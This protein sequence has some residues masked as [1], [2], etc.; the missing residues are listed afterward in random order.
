MPH[1][2]PLIATLAVGFVLAF[3][4]GFAAQRLRLP[5]LVGYLLAGVAIGPFT[6]GFVADAELAAQLAEVGVMLLMFGVGLHFSVADLMAVRRIAIPGAVLQIVLATVIGAALAMFWGWSL[7]AGLVL[8]LSL[9]VAS[10]VVLLK[11]L[12]ERNAI[13]TPN[14]RIAVGWLIVE[15]LAMVLVLVL[16]PAFAE[17]LGGTATVGGHA[18]EAAEHGLL[19]TLGITLAKVGCF[20]G[21]V[22]IFGP[23]L[24]PWILRQVARTGSRELFTLSVLAVALGVAFG[25]AKLFG[26]SFALGAFFAGVVLSESELSHRAAEKSLPLQDAFAVLF[27]VSVGML[28]D[29]SILLREPLMVLAVLAVILIGK[30]IIS[31]VIV[32]VL[33]YPLSTAL[34]VSSALAQ[35]GEFSFI[36][37]GIGVAHGLLPAEGLSLILAGALLSITVNPLVFVATD[38]ITTKIKA[39]EGWRRRFEEKRSGPLDRLQG[40]LDAVRARMAVKAAAHKT[41]SPEELVQKFPL[42]E[43]LSEE[44]REALVLHFHP[45]SAQPG[46]RV[47]RAGDVADEAYFISSGEVEVSVSGRRIKLRAGAVFG[48]MAL[49]SGQPRSADVTAIDYSEFLTLS[50]G[51]FRQFVRKYPSIRSQVAALAAQRGQMNEQWFE[52]SANDEP[53]D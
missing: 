47:I 17:V 16:L 48:E 32:M 39:N 49:L 15:D 40:E 41:F 50:R 12:E 36:L 33:G 25:S 28:F 42:F 46:E 9:S 31:L 1:D 3:I 20:V 34:S 52:A 38:F 30:S 24:V 23:R 11:A 19:L 14:G 13:A 4:F 44:Q 35:V 51:D 45:K 6:P 27:F 21:L 53:A 5:P 2:A 37:A 26:V 43:G 10:T 29:P 18:S 8:G 7:G 22:M